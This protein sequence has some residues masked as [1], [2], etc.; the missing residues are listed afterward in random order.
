M[1][2][3]GQLQRDAR[4]YA[5]RDIGLM[6]EQDD[7]RV[8]GDFCQRRIEIVGTEA[9]RPAV[10]LRRSISKLIAEAGEPER[11]AIPGETDDVVLI[12]GY[13]GRLQRPMGDRRPVPD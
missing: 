4:G 10:A 3:A 8:V 11:A 12:D 2:M 6:R 1:G 5:R 13:A 7:R 9:L